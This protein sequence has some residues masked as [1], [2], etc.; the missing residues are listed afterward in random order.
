[1]QNCHDSLWRVQAYLGPTDIRLVDSGRG[2]EADATGVFRRIAGRGRPRPRSPDVTP[3]NHDIDR[4]MGAGPDVDVAVRRPTPIS[5]A[6]C[7]SSTSS[8][9]WAASPAGTTT[10]SRASAPSHDRR[11]ATSRAVRAR[12]VHFGRAAISSPLCCQ[13]DPYGRR[14]PAEPGRQ[15]LGGNGPVGA[16]GPRQ[17]GDHGRGMRSRVSAAA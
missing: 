11:R 10:T 14:L 5:T 2:P 8:R 6:T 17:R 4:R 13:D 12:R 7:P 15:G 1:M 16:P 9:S 3:G